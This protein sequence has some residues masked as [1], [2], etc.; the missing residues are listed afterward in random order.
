M[1]HRSIKGI[2][3][4]NVLICI[5]PSLWEKWTQTRVALCSPFS[6]TY[7]KMHKHRIFQPFL[8]ML[9]PTSKGR[10]QIFLVLLPICF[11]SFSCCQLYIARMFTCMIICTFFNYEVL[12]FFYLCL[13][14]LCVLYLIIFYAIAINIRLK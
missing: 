11:I 8:L 9:F 1:F 3:Q 13:N 4:K 10:C 2:T 14:A 5:E 7:P 6:Q 12:T